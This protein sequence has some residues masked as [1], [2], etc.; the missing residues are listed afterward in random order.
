MEEKKYAEERFEFSLS[1]NNKLICSRNFKINGF[2]P[3][4]METIDFKCCI[5]DVVELI[6]NDLKDKSEIYTW[7]YED[8]DELKEPLLKP[9]ECTFKFTVTD[10]GHEVISKIW[11]GYCYPRSIRNRVDLTNKNVKIVDKNGT[12]YVYDKETF[13]EENSSKMSLRNSILREMIYNKPDLS[14]TITKMICE[15]CS[16]WGSEY[17]APNDYTFSGVYETRDYARNEDGSLILDENGK[18]KIVKDKEHTKKYFFSNSLLFN[19]KAAVWGMVL[20]EKT[21]EYF[22]SIYK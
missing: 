12:V 14:M 22:Q 10:N 19:K 8:F 5:D 4:S 17:K 11:D 13:F 16:S 6:Q 2:I 9:W 21:K 20:S 7:Y 18:P 3:N 1:I 15:A